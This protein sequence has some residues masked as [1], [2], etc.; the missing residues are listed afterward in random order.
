MS[1]NGGEETKII[2]E[3]KQN[4]YESKQN[5]PYE[6]NIEQRRSNGITES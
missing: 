4:K 6:K 1:S 2:K 5:G 3:F